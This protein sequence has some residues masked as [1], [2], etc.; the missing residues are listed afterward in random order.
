MAPSQ[1]IGNRQQSHAMK[2]AILIMIFL[3]AGQLYAQPAAVYSNADREIFREYLTTIEPYRNAPGD[4]ILEKSA[5]FFLNKPYLAHTLEGGD[6]EQ[7]T[8]NLRAFDCTTFVETVIALT[9][10]AISDAPSFETFMKELRSI[11]YRKGEIDGYAS[12]LHYATDWLQE[13]EQRGLLRNLS[14]SL[15]GVKEAKK[16]SFMSS[17]RD[18]YG[19]LKNDDLMLQL[20]AAREE[21]INQQGGFDYLPNEM[22]NEVAHLIPHMSVILFTTSTEGLDVTHMGFAFRKGEKLLFLHASSAGERVMID[23]QTLPEY[24]YKQ[25]Y[26]TGIIVAEIDPLSL[27]RSI[28]PLRC[29]QE[30]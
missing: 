11:R 21:M 28:I 25:P 29:V 8:V 24:T 27:R 17:H 14:P 1:S 15:G 5:L 23:R 3:A 6:R 4:T 13:N 20:I 2:T 7:L 22:I 26:C 16:L 9:L 12:R 19:R 10:T 30:Y 18:A